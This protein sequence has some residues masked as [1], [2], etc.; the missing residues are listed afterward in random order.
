MKA[1]FIKKITKFSAGKECQMK[2]H[3]IFINLSFLPSRLGIK[4]SEETGWKIRLSS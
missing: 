2:D 4:L 1:L 3:E